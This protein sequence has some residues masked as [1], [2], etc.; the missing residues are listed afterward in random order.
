M[1]PETVDPI[2]L[3]GERRNR[4]PVFGRAIDRETVAARSTMIVVQASANGPTVLSRRLRL[5]TSVNA[6][7]TGLSV[8]GGS[9]GGG[10]GC[11]AGGGGGG[12]GGVEALEEAEAQAPDR[13]RR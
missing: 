9:Y 5:P 13:R 3:P 10:W 12:V 1:R 8:D 2:W 6:G 11:G 7:G 4:A